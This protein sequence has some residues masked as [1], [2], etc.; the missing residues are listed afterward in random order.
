MAFLHKLSGQIHLFH[1]PEIQ[2]LLVPSLFQHIQN[3]NATLRQ[4][5]S[6]CLVMILAHQQDSTRRGDL[7]NTVKEELA[8]S[9]AFTMRKTYI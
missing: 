9:T 6:K 5:C 1:V 2:D 7:A 4:A 3:G 8:V